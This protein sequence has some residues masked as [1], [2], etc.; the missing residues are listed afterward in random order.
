MMRDTKGSSSKPRGRAS[1]GHLWG[2][3]QL[4]SVSSADFNVI[5]FLFKLSAITI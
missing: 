4:F 2:H 5:F 1:S 3:R